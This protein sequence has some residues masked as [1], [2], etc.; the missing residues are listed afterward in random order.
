MS[1]MNMRVSAAAL[2][3]LVVAAVLV[4]GCSEPSAQ[5]ARTAQNVAEY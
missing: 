5:S 3:A 2:S 4:G 1:M